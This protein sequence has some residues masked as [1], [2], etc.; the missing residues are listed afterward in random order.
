MVKGIASELREQIHASANLFWFQ[1]IAQCKTKAE[2]CKFDG[3][4]LKINPMDAL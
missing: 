1:C 2:R 3:S 4:F